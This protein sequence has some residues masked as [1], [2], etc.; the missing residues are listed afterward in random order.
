MGS[1]AEKYTDR[2]LRRQ[3]GL[4]AVA[5]EYAQRYVGTF[6]FMQGARDVV[7]DT[8]T[9]PLPLARGVLNCMRADPDADI[10]FS[11]SPAPEKPPRLEVVKSRPWR[12]D[13]PCRVKYRYGYAPN[14]TVLHVVERAVCEWQL[15]Y[16]YDVHDIRTPV[17]TAQWACK[18]WQRTKNVILLP[19]C[20]GEPRCR[21]CERKDP[22][23]YGTS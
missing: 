5:V 4:V 2:D 23:A 12:L 9:L 6:E 20:V 16:R 21:V 15:P 22:D 17:F 10:V 18:A 3:P 14:G 11:R 13:M 19:D 7:Y 8:G 1:E